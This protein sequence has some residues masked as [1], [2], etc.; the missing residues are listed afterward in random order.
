MGALLYESRL[1][2]SPYS[3]LL[4]VSKW[5]EIKS[6]FWQ[7]FCSINKLPQ[8]SCLSH[9]LDVGSSA[10]PQLIKVA[11]V[12]SFTAG[13]SKDYDIPV[14]FNKQHSYSSLICNAQIT[15]E[16][17]KQF[18]HHSAITCPISHEL[19]DHM[20]NPAMMLKCGHVICKNSVTKLCGSSNR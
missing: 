1:L 4:D 10:L 17:R 14:S 6:M 7:I 2:S 8:Y 9:V 13:C 5:Q 20:I 3:K 18:K 12:K 15:L 19:A 16:L 11:K